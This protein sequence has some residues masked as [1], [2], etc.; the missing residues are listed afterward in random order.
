MLFVY[1]T[2]G[3]AVAASGGR[4]KTDACV[5]KRRATIYIERED[6]AF[7]EDPRTPSPVFLVT[8]SHRPERGMGA[9]AYTV[10][11]PHITQ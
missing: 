5:Q 1:I 8:K 3:E 6:S 2:S 9:H 4:H 7:D 10:N 11:T